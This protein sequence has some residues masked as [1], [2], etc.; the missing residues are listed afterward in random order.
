MLILNHIITILFLTSAT[1]A[2]TFY[3]TTSRSNYT[4]MVECLERYGFRPGY[5]IC[6][7]GTMTIIPGN[8][9]NT[10]I[11]IY[12]AAIKCVRESD[13]IYGISM[14]DGIYE[15]DVVES[16]GLAR[17]LIENPIDVRVNCDPRRRGRFDKHN[18][19]GVRSGSSVCSTILRQGDIVSYSLLQ[20]LFA[21][22]QVIYPSSC[23]L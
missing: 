10:T 6:N 3:D 19:P 12:D 23:L 7:E 8:N 21:Q 14:C 13:F 16:Q 9:A 17:D 15:G 11:S 18:T 22:T 5:Y 4:V 2:A 1:F 20:Y